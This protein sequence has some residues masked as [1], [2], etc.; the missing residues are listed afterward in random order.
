MYVQDCSND[1]E[2]VLPG[3][4]GGEAGLPEGRDNGHQEAQMVPGT[5]LT[6]QGWQPKYPP[7]PPTPKKK[8]LKNT[9]S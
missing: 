3:Q 4:P 7:N 8:H 1:H 9:Q 5:Q 6:N 2:E